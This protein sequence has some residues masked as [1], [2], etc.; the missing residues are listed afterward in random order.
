MEDDSI[1]NFIGPIILVLLFFIFC[2]TESKISRKLMQL[3]PNLLRYFLFLLIFFLLSDKKIDGFLIFLNL[4]T[5][6]NLKIFL[7]SSFF[8]KKNFHFF[9]LIFFLN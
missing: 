5:N 1:G 8:L 4:L 7:Q 9:E 6:F 3:K 2:L